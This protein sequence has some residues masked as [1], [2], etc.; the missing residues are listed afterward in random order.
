MLRFMSQ[1]GAQG[2]SAAYEGHH[3]QLAAELPVCDALY[4][5]RRKQAAS[6]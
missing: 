2:F 3:E 1:E 4:A 6:S 5:W